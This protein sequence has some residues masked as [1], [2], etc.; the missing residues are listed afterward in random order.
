MAVIQKRHLKQ[1]TLFSNPEFS[2]SWIDQFTIAILEILYQQ[3]AILIDAL[4]DK[5]N[6]EFCLIIFELASNI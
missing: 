3:E 1:C 6:Y 2:L 4:L 5:D